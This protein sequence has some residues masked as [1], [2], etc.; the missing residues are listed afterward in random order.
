MPP[1]APHILVETR[2]ARRVYVGNVPHDASPDELVRFLNAAMLQAELNKWVGQPVLACVH[3]GTGFCFVECRDVD[4]ATELLKC[5]GAVFKGEALNIRRP[6][7]AGKQATPNLNQF[8]NLAL[9]MQGT[10]GPT[11]TQ[12]AQQMQMQQPAAASHQNNYQPPKPSYQQVLQRFLNK[13]K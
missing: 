10:I 1:L 2:Q 13:D 3:K 4:E 6:T 5:D 7:N 8:P 9:A 11:P 12:M